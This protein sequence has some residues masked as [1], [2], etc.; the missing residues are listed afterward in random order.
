LTLP[1]IT[2]RHVRFHLPQSGCAQKSVTPMFTHW[3]SRS[4]CGTRPP[5][6]HTERLLQ[7]V[8]TP[9]TVDKRLVEQFSSI[10]TS[11]LTGHRG[12]RSH[13]VD[14]K[15]Q[16]EA[17]TLVSKQMS[18][19]HL[20]HTMHCSTRQVSDFTFSSVVMAHAHKLDERDLQF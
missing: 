9:V 2:K 8:H 12:T 3:R 13:V 1:G 19:P 10:G 5:E 4:I 20:K 18:L 16:T 11:T 7:V 15:T 17:H 6:P 14:F